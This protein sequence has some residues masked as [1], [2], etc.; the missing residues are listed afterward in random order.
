MERKG[1]RVRG[2][3]KD[4]DKAPTVKPLLS[5]RLGLGGAR[6]TQICPYLRIQYKY[7]G[8]NRPHLL[9]YPQFLQCQH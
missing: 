4:R 6:I 9:Y 8:Y 1:G 2:P 5:G 3:G 7:I